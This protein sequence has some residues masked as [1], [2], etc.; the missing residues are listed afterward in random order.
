MSR[1]NDIKAP[2]GFL[3]GGLR[4]VRTDGTVLFQRGWWQCP[5]SWAGEVI[6]VHERWMRG[7][8]GAEEQKVEAWPPGVQIWAESAATVI[9]ERTERRDAKAGYRDPIHKAW[10]QR[11]SAAPSGDRP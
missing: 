5:V 7:G 8:K 1:D 9:L 6:W 3:L 4:K 10:S 2:D 11:G